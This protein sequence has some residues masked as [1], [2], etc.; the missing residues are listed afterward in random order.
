M[1]RRTI[2]YGL[3]GVPGTHHIS[4]YARVTEAGREESREDYHLVSC[5]Q[6]S[7]CV[8]A[9]LRGGVLFERVITA[10]K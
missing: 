8:C 2:D 10:S 3:L 6:I 7:V 1:R 5:E 9:S 4:Q